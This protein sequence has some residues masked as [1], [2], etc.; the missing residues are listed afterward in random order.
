MNRPGWTRLGPL[1]WALAALCAAGCM[2]PMEKDVQRSLRASLSESSEVAAPRARIRSFYEKRHFVPLWT[3]GDGLTPQGAAAVEALCEEGGHGLPV[4]RV[5][6][7]AAV[8]R[9][10]YGDTPDA[11]SSRADAVAEAEMQLASAVLE[12][13]QG[14]LHG[15]ASLPRMHRNWHYEVDRDSVA[16]A[17]LL[18]RFA[19]SRSLDAT[20]RDLFD[21][22]PGYQKI[23]RALAAYRDIA[24]RG[25]WPVIPAG[26]DLSP[27]GRGPRIDAV[28]ARLVATG[29]MPDRAG[30]LAGAV[31]RF[32][33]RH[34]I[35]PGEAIDGET[36]AAMNVPVEQRIAQLEVNLERQRWLPRFDSE[37]I[38]VNIPEFKLHAYRGGREV[39]NMNVITGKPMNQTP[40]FADEMTYVSIRP[41]WNVPE[42]IALEEL[43]PK[44]EEDPGYLE[45]NGYEVVNADG[46]VVQVG[47]SMLASLIP[48]GGGAG[49]LARGIEDGTLQIRQRPSASN[50]LGLIKFMFPNQFN[51]YLHHTP[52][53]HLFAKSQRDFS[54]GCIRVEDPVALGAFVLAKNGDWDADRIAEAMQDTSLTAREVPLEDP[55]PVYIVY[56]TAWVDDSGQVQFRDDVYGHDA[57]MQADLHERAPAERRA[58]CERLRTFLP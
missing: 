54:H 19:S 41:Y 37:R 38:V 39:L 2:T 57:R 51:V 45:S 24:V 21:V 50:A 14:R 56:L 34:G 10:A 47:N 3:N 42:S 43:I 11:G 23:E 6:Q 46:E 36:I 17:E 15:R 7:V 16:P 32:Q 5:E 31:R 29:D 12:M 9:R 48:G 55:I 28:R 53:E 22:H 40:I 13:I 8:L 4:D 44:V 49:E 27:A 18:Q 33:A 35:E 30:D 25:G 58:V 52:S 20:V 26:P 1:G